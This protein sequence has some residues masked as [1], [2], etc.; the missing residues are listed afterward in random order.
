MAVLVDKN[1]TSKFFSSVTMSP[2]D[3]EKLSQGSLG[4]ALPEA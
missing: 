2:Q 4:K 1:H 3:L